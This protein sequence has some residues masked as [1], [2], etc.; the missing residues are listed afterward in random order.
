MAKL[1]IKKIREAVLKHRALNPEI[2]DY[3]VMIIWN[4]LGE[5]TKEKYLASIEK[6]VKEK[7]PEPRNQKPETKKENSDAVSDKTKPN[8]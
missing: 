7:K 3:Q 1:S 5:R 6:E 2:A 4:S 8:L